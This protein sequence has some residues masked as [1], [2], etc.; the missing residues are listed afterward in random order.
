MKQKICIWATVCLIWISRASSQTISGTVVDAATNTPIQNVNVYI[1]SQN[2]GTATSSSG[3]FSLDYTN[4]EKIILTFSHIGYA[5]K[6]IPIRVASTSLVIAMDDMFFAMDDIVVTST[7]TNKLN[8]DVPIAT[9]VILRKD[10]MDSGSLH[11]EDLLNGYSGVSLQTSVDGGSILNI[12]GMDSRYILILV[13]GQPITGKFNNHVSLNQIPASQVKKIEII[14]GPN[15]SLYGSE[16]MA[17]VI[18]II[19]L[20][21][22]EHNVT[23]INIR[24]NGSEN[25]LKSEGLNHGSESLQFSLGRKMGTVTATISGNIELIETDKTIQQIDADNISKYSGTIDLEWKASSKHTFLFKDIHYNHDEN[26]ASSLMNAS[27]RIKRNSASLNHRWHFR[28]DWNLSHTLNHSYYSRVYVQERPWGDLV[29]DDLTKEGSI[30]YENLIQKK[31]NSGEL[32]AGFEG[33]SASYTSDRLQNG[34]QSVTAA[35]LFGQYDFFIGE[36]INMVAGIRL[37]HSSEYD[38]VS[39][40]R[41]GLMYTIA[42]RWKIRTTWGK[43]FRSPSFMERFI[44]WNHIQFSYRV[45][46]NAELKPELSNG[47][48][49]GVEY[50]HPASYKVSLMLYVTDFKN[51]IEDYTLQPGLLSYRNIEQATY[52]GLELQGKWIISHS[53]LSSWGFNLIDNR[54]ASGD[55]I[56]NTQ[57]LSAYTRLTYK[58][59]NRLWNGALRLKWVG[60]YA[61]QDYNPDTGEYEKASRSLDAYTII[62]INGSMNVWKQINLG[63]GIR[64]AGNYTHDRYGPFIGRSFYIEILTNI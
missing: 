38:A 5:D 35:S 26:G 2:V 33:S 44:D 53:W 21:N 14:K 18:N 41:I 28:N 64:N 4:A 59:Q 39:S 10:I 1:K 54:N 56:P 30:K 31:S 52:R 57:P 22:S 50:Y 48:T 25:K 20:D 15:S 61:P 58:S 27:T 55:L 47:F 62:N 45:L 16:A 29:T 43:G 23:S 12:L 7:R 13:D 34:T 24:Y 11:V 32:N 49:A 8:K 6:S 37:D 40:P 46:G 42:E 63:I 60:S 9:E 3:T 36:A 19:T 51:L 17:G